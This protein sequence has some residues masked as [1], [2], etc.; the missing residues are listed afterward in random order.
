MISLKSCDISIAEWARYSHWKHISI[1][2]SRGYKLRIMRLIKETWLEHSFSSR[3]D[4]WHCAW[5][6]LFSHLMHDLMQRV[7][8]NGYRKTQYQSCQRHSRELEVNNTTSNSRL[9]VK[10]VG[11]QRTIWRWLLDYLARDRGSYVSKEYKI[12]FINKTVGFLFQHEGITNWSKYLRY[13]RWYQ[14][15]SWILLLII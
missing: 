7:Y 11:K 1:L 5:W 13:R 8:Q 2:L 14:R 12:T 6:A 3:F 15:A 4:E 10:A 9:I